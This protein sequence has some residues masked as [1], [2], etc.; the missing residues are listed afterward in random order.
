M[1]TVFINERNLA[2]TDDSS[3]DQILT[4]HYP[5]AQLGG[6][7]VALHEEVVPKEKWGDTYP[8]HGDRMVLLEAW[9]GG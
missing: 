8:N 4:L 7:A 5:E 2:V 6:V 9:Q 3:I 1:K